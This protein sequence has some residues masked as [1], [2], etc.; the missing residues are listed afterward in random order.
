MR[1]DDNQQQED[2]GFA[3]LSSLASDIEIPT[4]SP[5][6]SDTATEPTQEEWRAPHRRSTASGPPASQQRP[7]SPTFDEASPAKW[8]IGVTIV[9]GLVWLGTRTASVVPAPTASEYLSPTIPD[10]LTLPSESKPPIGSDLVLTPAQVRYCV[11]EEIRIDGAKAAVNDT[12]NDDIARFNDMVTDYNQRC[13]SFRYRRGVL[14]GA[15][16]DVEPYRS[17]LVSEGQRRI[18]GAES[19][20]TPS[21]APAYST[22]QTLHSI[23]SAVARPDIETL[24]TDE[25]DAID[26]ACTIA[27]FES[28]AAYDKCLSTQMAL[29]RNAPPAP[30]LTQLNQVEVDAIRTACVLDK[31][32]GAARYNRCLA[33]QVRALSSAPPTPDLSALTY[34]ERNAIEI[35]CVV[36]KTKGA[37]R[38]NK[39]LTSQMT[40]LAAGPRMPD[41]SGLSYEERNTVSFACALE[42]TEGAASY[43]RCLIRQLRAVKH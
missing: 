9:M 18:S 35:A 13:G 36:A 22:P 30:D 40:Q 1:K 33:A 41:L 26:L 20:A 3:G 43:N 23:S 19:D 39:C 27:K 28:A 38:Y 37:A 21:P 29:L 31:T 6:P 17:Q 8:I 2:R 10:A 34:E 11:A 25:K 5:G 42:Q 32:E 12:N 4:S 24:A 15:H 16:R 7:R 14:D